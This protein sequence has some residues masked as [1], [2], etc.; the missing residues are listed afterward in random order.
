MAADDT[1]DKEVVEDVERLKIKYIQNI[2]EE[3]IR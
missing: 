1:G 3:A 2:R